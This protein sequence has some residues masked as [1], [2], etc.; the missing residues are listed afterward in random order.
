MDFLI[1]FILEVYMELMTLI[2]PEKNVTK[3]HKIIAKILAVIVIFAIF[4]LVV[5]GLALIIDHNNYLGLIPLSFALVISLLQIIFGIIL[6]K[7]NH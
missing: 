1:E 5:W 2:V 6:Y 7:R 3:K 4:A